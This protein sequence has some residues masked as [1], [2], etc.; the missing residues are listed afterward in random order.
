MQLFSQFFSE[1]SI[2]HK[3]NLNI[4]ES[5]RF[6]TFVTVILETIYIILK[7]NHILQNISIYGIKMIVIF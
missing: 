7:I 5:L 3:K 6:L 1:K 2:N 4:S